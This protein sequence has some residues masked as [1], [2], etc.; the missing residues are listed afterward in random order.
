MFY[1]GIQVKKTCRQFQLLAFEL[2][3]EA[4][5]E[6]QLLSTSEVEAASAILNHSC[7]NTSAIEGRSFSEGVTCFSIRSR[8]WA[9]FAGLKRPRM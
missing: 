6:V 1:M 2:L 7:F 9:E 3:E 4:D 5:L 8:A